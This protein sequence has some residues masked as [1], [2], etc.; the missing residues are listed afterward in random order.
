[1]KRLVDVVQVLTAMATVWTVV[2]LLTAQAPVTGDP[3]TDDGARL[4]AARCSSCHGAQGQG[5][6]G[7]RLAGR[8][9]EKYPNVEDQL[10]IVANGREGMPAFGQ[11]LTLEEL[12]AVVEFTRTKLGA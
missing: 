9:V 10:A 3:I 7:P 1:V 12:T 6:R 2:L 11:R 4:Y 5:L 8:V